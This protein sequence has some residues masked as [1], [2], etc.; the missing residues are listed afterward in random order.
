MY[1]FV[2][3]QLSRI[4][5]PVEKSTGPKGTTLNPWLTAGVVMNAI[6]V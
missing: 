4:K 2:G 1:Y 5:N 3:A 6:R